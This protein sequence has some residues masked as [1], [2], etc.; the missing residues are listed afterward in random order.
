MIYFYVLFSLCLLLLSEYSFRIKSLLLLIITYLLF[1]NFY[2]YYNLSDYLV[3]SAILI[4]ITTTALFK[5]DNLFI[6]VFEII[7]L[8]SL[9]LIEICL[10]LYPQTYI[11]LI[12]KYYL[13]LDDFYI[14]TTLFIIFSREVGYNPF[15]MNEDNLRKYILTAIISYITILTLF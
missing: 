8:L 6:F 3:S 12:G 7:P 9:K 5:K 15:K 14:S 1:V 2:S 11:D 10:V 13:Y 4:V